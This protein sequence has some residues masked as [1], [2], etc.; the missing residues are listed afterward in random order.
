VKLKKLIIAE[1]LLAVAILLVILFFVEITPYLESSRQNASIGLYNQREYGKGNATIA[2]GQIVRAAQFN[3]TT[4]DPA[5]LILDLT[6]Q[7]WKSTGNLT[8]AINGRVF[9]SILATPENSQMSLAVITVSGEDWVE[10]TSLNS[11]VFGNEIT[12]ISSRENGYEGTFDYQ[13]S[14]RGSR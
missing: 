13:I 3:Y 8:F 6:F 7:N 10:T 2:R 1:T 9:S 14:V 12:F 11:L 4:S 5:I